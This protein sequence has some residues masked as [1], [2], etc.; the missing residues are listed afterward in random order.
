E[1]YKQYKE[2]ERHKSA[3]L[4]ALRWRGLD[5]RIKQLDGLIGELEVALEARIAEQRHADAEIEHLRESHNEVQESFN[6][7]QQSYYALGAEVAR[8]E[9][10]IQHQRERRQQLFEELEQISVSWK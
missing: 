8:L 9:Q 6:Q 4:K 5:R 3:Q 10:S 7:V 1:K 2:E